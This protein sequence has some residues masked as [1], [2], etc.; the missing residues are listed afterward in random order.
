[1]FPYRAHSESRRRILEI[2]HAF[3]FGIIIPMSFL[4]LDLGRESLEWTGCYY[5]EMWGVLPNIA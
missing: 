4:P 1:M 3:K 5:I 2:D